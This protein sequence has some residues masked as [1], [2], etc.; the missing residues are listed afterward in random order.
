MQTCLSAVE[1]DLLPIP[2]TV[3]VQHEDN[4]GIG[5]VWGFYPQRCHVESPLPVCPGM[6]VSLSLHLPGTGRVRIEQCL[7]TWARSSEFGLQFTHVSSTS[8]SEGNAI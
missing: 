6:T 8:R 1:V 2:C 5:T 7:V 3:Y 4:I